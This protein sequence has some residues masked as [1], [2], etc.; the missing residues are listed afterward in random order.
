MS[1]P[2][3]YL[4]PDDT[5]LNG[6]SKYASRL[7]LALKKYAPQFSLTRLNEEEFLRMYSHFP[8][9]SLV[10]AEMSVGEG[11]IFQALTEQK[12]HRPD[13]RR[14][15]TLHDPPRFVTS[16]APWL[17]TISSTIIGRA[18][19]K[20]FVDSLGE[21]YERDMLL[22]TDTL[23]TLSHAGREVLQRKV[24]R[25][26]LGVS[27]VYL[28]HLLPEDVPLSPYRPLRQGTVRVG[29]FGYIN[30]HKGID[31][32]LD[33]A[34]HLVKRHGLS[35]VPEFYVYGSASSSRAREYLVAMKRK[36]EQYALSEKV[37]FGDGLLDETI[38]AFLD[39]LDALVLPYSDIGFISASGVLQWSRSRAVPVVAS[40]TRAF[41]SL[42]QDKV[43]GRLIET[44]SIPAWAD[45][46]Y[47]IAQR[48]P[49][50]TQ[51][52]SGIAARQAEASWKTIAAE[53]A[54]ILSKAR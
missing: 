34:H 32:L 33:A 18:A 22:S 47:G 36:T 16:P 11:K 43:D 3:Y 8:N 30:P 6:I 27:V 49:E 2:I 45:A 12:K 48:L 39:S 13:L 1:L 51:M 50:W 28:P 9:G 20:L 5:P 15:I 41:R 19:R 37:I 35:A 25:F 7:I 26:N 4:A 53:L 29:Q 10:M 21:F 40:A 46:L 52:S 44:T 24:A 38:P 23:I 42:I 17:E 31:V 54:G 14:V